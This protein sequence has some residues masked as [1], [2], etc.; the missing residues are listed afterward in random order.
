[1]VTPEL[2]NEGLALGVRE[3]QHILTRSRRLE[4]DPRAAR[5]TDPLDERAR[6][7]SDH[8]YER[9]TRSRVLQ[10]DIDLARG[11]LE[12]DLDPDRRS[13]LEDQESRESAQ[14]YCHAVSKGRKGTKPCRR[15]AGL[16]ART[17]RPPPGQRVSSAA[18]KV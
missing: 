17:A 4:Q 15:H 18:A 10:L 1:M 16:A 6:G 8:Q 13:R 7:G 12:G 2:E 9:P 5:E 3:H 14:R 11:S